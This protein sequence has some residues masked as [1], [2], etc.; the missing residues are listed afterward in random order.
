M[1]FKDHVSY[2]KTFQV[3]ISRNQHIHEANYNDHAWATVDI[4]LYWNWRT[5]QGHSRSRKLS[6]TKVV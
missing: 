4:L 3:N 2:Q 6:I 5:V 1:T